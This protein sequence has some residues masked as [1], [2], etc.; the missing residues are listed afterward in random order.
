MKTK[1]HN[2]RFFN[3]LRDRTIHYNIELEGTVR[4]NL[5]KTV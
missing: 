3:V 4:E 5:Y 2:D 1:Q